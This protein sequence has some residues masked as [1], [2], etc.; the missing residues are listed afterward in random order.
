MLDILKNKTASKSRFDTLIARGT[1]I[2]G[3]VIF[4][5]GLH[6]DG[7]VEGQIK[8]ADDNPQAIVR[9]SEDGM[10][11]GNI[12]APEVIINGRVQGNVYSSEHVVLAPKASITGNVYYNLIEMAVGAEVNGNLVHQK[13][14]QPK[15]DV[16][17]SIVSPLAGTSE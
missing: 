6:V 16:P 14:R 10:V 15:S 5:G 7:A 12:V 9:L 2:K 17:V 4:T 13:D 8:A 11:N 3:D 1:E